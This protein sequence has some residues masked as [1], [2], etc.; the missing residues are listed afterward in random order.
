MSVVLLLRGTYILLYEDALLEVY[1]QL[2]LQLANTVSLFIYALV[3]L[4]A[5]AV[6]LITTLWPIRPSYGLRLFARMGV[7]F[8]F[9]QFTLN[10]MAAPVL[11][12]G[13]IT[14]LILALMAVWSVL[15][16]RHGGR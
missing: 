6:S 8:C 2:Y 3:C 12:V 1:P 10:Q 14:H 4:L 5:G 16:T 13:A 11:A 15:R 9:V 7:A